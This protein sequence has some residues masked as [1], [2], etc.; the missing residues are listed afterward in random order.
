MIKRLILVQV[1]LLAFQSLVYFGCEMFQHR[2]HNVKLRIDD[3]I[4][5]LPW[6]VFFY[7]FWFP[8]I[9][10]YPLVVYQTDPMY[11]C[12]YLMSMLL[13]VVISVL[14]YLIYP[15]SFTRPVPP[16][17]FWGRFMKLIYHGSYRGLNCAPSLHC[18]SCF[19]VIWVSCACSG[20][21][22]WIRVLT[23]AV[24]V[25]I[26]LSTMTTKQHTIVDVL[27]AVPLFIVCRVLGGLMANQYFPIILAYVGQ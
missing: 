8:L 24:A 23:I 7:C 26:V 25:L 3:K 20:M 5:F 14:C 19:L 13:E 6:S 4:S 22:M 10:V 9:A 15:T 27:T 17:T 12:I 21:E 1:V 16:N 11:Y 2:I 18:S